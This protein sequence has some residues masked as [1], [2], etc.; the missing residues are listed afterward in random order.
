VL[1][2]SVSDI[3]P[4]NLYLL[5]KGT[6]QIS[7]YL[8]QLPAAKQRAWAP[9]RDVGYTARDGYV[10][11]AYLTLPLGTPAGRKVPLVALVHGGPMIRDSWLFNPEVQFF[12]ALGYGV[13][14]VNY[15]G[16]AGL[17]KD[18]Q[19]TSITEVCRV[20]VD[21]VADGI[22]WCAEEGYSDP[23]RVAVVGGSFGGYVALAVAE[24]YPALPAAVVGFAGVYDWQDQMRI[25]LDRNDTYFRWRDL[26][27]PDVKAHAA[28]YRAVSPVRFAA[29]VRA[30]VLLLHGTED[31]RVDV[32][33][34]EA[35]DKALRRA[36]KAVWLVTDVA[37][38]H[39]LPDEQSRLDYYRTVAEFLDEHVPPAR[40]P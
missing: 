17:G 14:Q 40:A 5:Q 2:E 22:R 34:S 33:Q 30:P 16:S 25:D 20:S 27:Y 15:R 1:I 6:G 8:P 19:L 12:V 4:Q 7:L 32:E 3:R 13:L 11:H 38:I 18:H 9:M 36:G 29:A 35:M 37:S 23:A 10:L 39:G 28:E 24:R 31:Q 21:D 26:Y